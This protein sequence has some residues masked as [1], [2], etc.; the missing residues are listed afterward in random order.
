[1]STIYVIQ[2]RFKGSDDLWDIDQL[3]PGELE[4]SLNMKSIHAR[5]DELAEAF[6][7]HEFRVTPVEV[8]DE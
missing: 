6:T 8:P 1:M 3:L 5:R 7:D 4:A 2:M